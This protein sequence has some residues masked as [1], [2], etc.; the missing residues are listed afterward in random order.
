MENQK[1]LFSWRG[2]AATE[3]R[4]VQKAAQKDA[5]VTVLGSP[6]KTAVQASQALVI[7]EKQG[8]DVTHSGQTRSPYPPPPI[9]DELM[10]LAS[11]T[12]SSLQSCKDLK[13]QTVLNFLPRALREGSPGEL[14]LEGKAR[15]AAPLLAQIHTEKE[16]RK[17]QEEHFPANLPRVL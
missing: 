14:D 7:K 1:P 12:S 5:T 2:P 6:A 10:L 9:L 15:P 4:R 8:L 3:E 13:R 17:K 11:A 16:T